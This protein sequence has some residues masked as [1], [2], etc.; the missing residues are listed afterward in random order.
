MT[1]LKTTKKDQAE[2]K[3]YILQ[4]INH[5]VKEGRKQGGFLLCVQLHA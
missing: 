3:K 1:I 2:A 5:M 4:V